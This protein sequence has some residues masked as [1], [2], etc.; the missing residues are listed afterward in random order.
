M[1][2]LGSSAST[3]KHILL[4]KQVIE[5]TANFGGKKKHAKGVSEDYLSVH[6][7]RNDS[8]ESF[9]K[10]FMKASMANQSFT[11]Q[12]HIMINNQSAESVASS[13]SPKSAKRG[14]KTKGL[15]IRPQLSLSDHIKLWNVEGI[16]GSNAVKLNLKQPEQSNYFENA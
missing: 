14:V 6:H 15:T 4:R 2:F 7:E 1:G 11:N 3:A 10:K 9:N 8:I 16:E 12:Q 5:K 13:K